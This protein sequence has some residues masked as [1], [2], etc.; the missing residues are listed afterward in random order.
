ME[1]VFA[2]ANSR[3]PEAH[4]AVVNFRFTGRGQQ[5]TSVA[6]V[7]GS[8]KII[9]LLSDDFIPNIT[10]ATL[11]MHMDCGTD[12]ATSATFEIR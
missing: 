5:N 6:G 12:D 8:V 2:T 1:N 10:N 9:M 11:M 4:S 7:R 3:F